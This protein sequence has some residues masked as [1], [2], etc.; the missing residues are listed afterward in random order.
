MTYST[1][2]KTIKSMLASF[3]LDDI[4]LISKGDIIEIKAVHELEE[5]ILLR[6]KAE[7]REIKLSS[8]LVYSLQVTVYDEIKDL[9]TKNSPKRYFRF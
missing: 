6:G 2:S 9:F 7:L 1:E 4:S 3:S 5:I 8:G